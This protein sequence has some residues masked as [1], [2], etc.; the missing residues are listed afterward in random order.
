MGKSLFLVNSVYHLLTTVHIKH[1]VFPWEEA[2]LVVTD[3]TPGLSGLAPRLRE[4][5]LFQRVILAETKELSSRFPMNEEKAVAQCFGERETTLQW[6]LGEELER[7]YSQVFFPNCDWLARLLACRYYSSPCPFYWVEDGFS[8]YVVDFFNP[9]RAAVNRHA[10]GE[11]LKEKTQA[12]L[13]YEP[14][15]AMRGDSIPN[16][17]IPKLSRKDG[18]LKELLN[19]IFDYRPPRELPPFLFLEQ[20]FR[21]EN[22]QGNDLELMARCQQ[23]VGPGNFGVKPHPRNGDNLPQSMGLTRKIDLSAPWELFLLNQERE[24]PTVI[25]V[26]SNGALSGRICLG[27]DTSTVMLYKLYTGKVLWKENEI[28]AR[29]LETFRRQFAGKQYYVPQTVYELESI[30]KYLGGQHGN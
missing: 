21:T 29:Y 30:L 4:T 27:L 13:L 15:L 1:N 26:C 28:L 25:T 10:E 14:R 9:H 8:S 23:V 20:S 11:K 7:E 18:E 2:D 24:I 17:S 6:V 16:R 19:F 12:A 22:I 3:A 5:G